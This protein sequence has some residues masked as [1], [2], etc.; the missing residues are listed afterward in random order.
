MV[1]GECVIYMQCCGISSRFWRTWAWACVRTREHLMQ[2]DVL[3][4]GRKKR[5]P[6]ETWNRYRLLH[7][8]FLVGETQKPCWQEHSF[9]RSLHLV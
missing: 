7:P 2:V 8:V 6:K 1:I 3:T 5:D 9:K 4:P